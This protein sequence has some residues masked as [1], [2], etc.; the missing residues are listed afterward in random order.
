MRKLLL[1]SM[2]IVIS[3][4]F[5]LS[6]GWV[7]A[8]NQSSAESNQQDLVELGLSYFRLGMFSDAIQTLKKGLEGN[9]SDKPDGRA[10][11]LPIEPRVYIMKPK[12]PINWFCDWMIK[13]RGFG[14]KSV[15]F[16]M[17]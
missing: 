16:I 10:W 9:T 15:I 4:L 11:L 8:Q 14:L 5:V 1:I 17:I 2:M 6:T 7:C 3:L 13:T 12:K